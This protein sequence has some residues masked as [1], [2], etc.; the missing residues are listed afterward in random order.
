MGNT[1]TMSVL[2]SGVG[3]F[4]AEMIYRKLNIIEI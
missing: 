3:A 1:L 4:T 2:F